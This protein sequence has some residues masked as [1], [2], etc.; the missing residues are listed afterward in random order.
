MMPIDAN[1]LFE[2]LAA[3]KAGIEL[4]PGDLTVKIVMELKGCK[5]NRARDRLHELERKGRVTFI[6]WHKTG[7]G[8]EMVFR[9]VV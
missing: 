6:G 5:N 1:K 2:E 9:P 3:E 8:K 7:N 4:Q